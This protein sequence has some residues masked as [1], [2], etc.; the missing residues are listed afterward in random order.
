M[1]KLLFLIII[2]SVL[3]SS[4]QIVDIPFKQATSVKYSFHEDL[5]QAELY[6]IV[7]DYNNVVYLLTDNGLFREYPG[8]VISKDVSYRALNNIIPIDICTQ[9]ETGFLFYLYEDR[10]LT[11]SYAGTVYSTIG[12]NKYKK[13]I[14]NKFG[15]ILLI[16]ENEVAIFARNKMDYSFQFDL[17]WKNI[18]V[19][20]GEFYLQNEHS[21]YRLKNKGWHKIH[22]SE[23]IT[24]LSFVGD[25]ILVGTNNGFYSLNLSDFS[26]RTKKE[27]KL[28]VSKITKILNV[29]GKN[30]FTTP[31][32]AFVFESG[33]YRYFASKRWLNQNNIIDATFDNNGN[34]YFLT[35]DGLNKVEYI[36]HT[37]AEKARY[38]EENIRKYH[39]RYGFVC[40]TRLT[41]PFDVTTAEIIDHDNDGL[42]TSFYLGSQAFRYAT[43]KEP[44]AKEYCWESFEAFERLLSVNPL[45]G[46]PSRTFERKGFK[47]SDP[48]RWRNS[49][50]PEW[51]WKG[52]TSSDE[53]V[54]YIFVAA[55]MDKLVVENDAER[56][57]IAVFIDQIMTHIIENDYYFIDSDGKPTTWG[58]WNPEYVNMYPRHVFDR[59]LNST[60]LIAGLQLAYHLTE[61]EIYKTEA[62]KMINEFGYL[63]NMMVSMINMKPDKINYDGIIMG[64]SWNHSDD[65]M[66]FLTYWP[67]YH[68]AYNDSLK[69]KYKWII[70]DHLEIE[71]PERNAAWNIISYGLS[72]DID[73][74]STL[75]HLHEFKL[76]LMSYSIRNSHRKDIDFLPENFRNQTTKRLLTPGERTTHRHNANPF[77]LDGGSDGTSKL[78][79]DEFLLP[80]W[81]C[82][83]YGVVVS[84]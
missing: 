8:N 3:N 81:M 18:Y 29:N 55:V 44:I 65:E 36:T 28:P 39:M 67:L 59:K 26:I 80:Y 49:Q 15:S 45:K 20:N 6:K 23:D 68:Y 30:W 57:R 63:E 21:I 69:E 78:A 1:N 54:A 33:E 76:D 56:K 47:V 41:T 25:K 73:V 52:T 48:K 34:I 64:D 22:E 11:N 42:W 7:V 79:G 51:E 14:V 27:N 31:N 50:E 24:C 71:K 13:I 60:L 46:F 62:F 83:Y 82:R 40:A 77:Q 43:T 35:P 4:G 58:R 2:C 19:Y 70:R 84:E 10:F 38:F 12:K 61:K 32:G 53:F 72:G 37:L 17:N 5:K 16:G 75:W 66:A 9:E 74:E